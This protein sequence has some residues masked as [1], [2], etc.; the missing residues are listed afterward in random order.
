MEGRTLCLGLDF[1]FWCRMISRMCLSQDKFCGTQL[2][3]KACDR[4]TDPGS[5]HH[6]IERNT[7][8]W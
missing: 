5:H 4:H 7:G 8:D 1:P 6:M 2:R 3:F